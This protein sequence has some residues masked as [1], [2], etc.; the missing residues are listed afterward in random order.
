MSEAGIKALMPVI[1][2]RFDYAAQELFL[3]GAKEVTFKVKLDDKDS[4]NL[5][6][7]YGE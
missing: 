1:A 7:S 6:I 3:E 5:S 2:R 4:F